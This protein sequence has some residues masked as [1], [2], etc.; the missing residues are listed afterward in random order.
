MQRM[1]DPGRIDSAWL[2]SYQLGGA[3]PHAVIGMLKW[4]RIIND[5]GKTT[6]NGWDLLRTSQRDSL[7]RLVRD[8]YAPVFDAVDIE[9]ADRT[10]IDGAFIH[11]Y[12]SGDTGKPVTAFLTLCAIAGIEVPAIRPSRATAAKTAPAAKKA[13]AV[14]KAPASRK[15][16]ASPS[17]D[18]GQSSES[19]ESTAR[20][21]DSRLVSMGSVATVTFNVEIPGDWDSARVRERVVDVLDAVKSFDKT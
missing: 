13:P 7:E 14:K 10:D 18:G 16:S 17:T 15:S 9:H 3:Q 21:P 2:T 20:L 1:G 8:S 5:D 12:R 11:A 6:G 19:R 4:L